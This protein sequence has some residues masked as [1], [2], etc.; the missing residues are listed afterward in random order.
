MP[1]II[2]DC[3]NRVSCSRYWSASSIAV[4]HEV[5][6]SPTSV[7]LTHFYC[8]TLSKVRASNDKLAREFGLKHFKYPTLIAVC[9]GE[10]KTAIEVEWS[11]GSQWT[12]LA[13]TW[14]SWSL[15]LTLLTSAADCA[16]A[17]PSTWPINSLWSILS[18]SLIAALYPCRCSRATWRTW[19]QWRLSLFS[20]SSPLDA[21][22][23]LQRRRR[24]LRAE[25]QSWSRS[26]HSLNLRYALVWRGV[27]LCCVVLCCVV[28]CGV[29]WC[30][31]CRTNRAFFRVAPTLHAA[32]PS[33]ILIFRL[34]A[35]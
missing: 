25:S 12:S 8:L 14:S 1:C 33:L 26:H 15:P 5:L 20:S 10:L 16:T 22:Y 4:A 2:S 28:L 9:A 11:L 19:Q 34:H 7:P 18:P 35:P 32:S 3:A 23:S 24:S 17:S 13:L 27:V 29:V 21:E 6:P 31:L 30:D